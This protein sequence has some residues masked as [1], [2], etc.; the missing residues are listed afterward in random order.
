MKDILV[1]E[2]GILDFAVGS[3]RETLKQSFTS[4]IREGAGILWP[5]S[6]GITKPAQEKGFLRRFWI[7]PQLVIRNPAR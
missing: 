5:G 2:M 1:K 6:F 4:G 3:P 7:I